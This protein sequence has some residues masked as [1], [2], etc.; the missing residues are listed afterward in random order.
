MTLF[1]IKILMKFRIS[2]LCLLGVIFFFHVALRAQQPFQYSHFHWDKYNV[3]PAFGGMED[4]MNITG[5]YRTQWQNLS[6]N[7]EFIRVNVHLPLYAVSGGTGV[8]VWNERIGAESNIML[9][10]TYNQVVPLAFGLLSIGAKAGILSKSIDG[11][12]LISATGTYQNG[13]VQHMDEYIPGIKIRAFAPVW[14]LSAYFF[15]SVAD[16]GIV[17]DD[18]PIVAMDFNGSEIQ[19]KNSIT[20]HGNYFLNLLPAIKMEAFGLFRTDFI[21]WQSEVGVLVKLRN[22]MN[23]SFLLRGYSKKTLDAVSFGLGSRVNNDLSIAY[24][25]D[26]TLSPLQ[27]NSGGTHEILLRYTINA[28]FGKK[29]PESIIYSPRLYD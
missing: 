20:V 7:P 23:A 1:Q 8:Q 16:F 12:Q 15:S 13:S 5:S 28:D 3:N 14:G 24:S 18:Y 9:A 25:Y 10:G 2:L 26:L 6:G 19:K 11:T 21:Q 27:N 4:K 22:T 17:F 29:I